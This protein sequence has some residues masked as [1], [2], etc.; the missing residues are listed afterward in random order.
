MARRQ[1]E[2]KLKNL[3]PGSKKILA[4][5]LPQ[6][7]KH[8]L[9]IA[10]SLLAILAEVGL[11]LLEPWPLKFIFDKLLVPELE[12]DSVHLVLSQEIGPLLLLSGL[13]L[14]IVSI[15]VL[16]ALATYASKLSM[17]MVAAK[18]LSDIRSQLYS[19]LQRLSLSFHYQYK[20]GDLISRVTGDIENIRNGMIDA[21]VPFA[22]NTVTLIGMIVVM[23]FINWELAAIALTMLLVFLLVANYLIGYIR[24]SVRKHRKSEAII[25][26]TTSETIGA[27]KIVQALSLHDALERI[28]LVQNRDNLDR[29]TEALKISALLLRTVQIL[30]AITIAIVLWRGAILV[31]NKSLTPGDLLVFISYLKNSFEPPL[32]KFANQ[33]GAIVK[34]IASGERIVDILE[35]EPNVRNLT[36]AKKAHPFFGAIKFENVKFGYNPNQK[37]LQGLNLAVEAGQKI[38]VVGPSGSGK[39]TLISLLLRLYDPN[40][41]RILI[42]GQDLREYTLESL[43]SQISVVLQ[44]SY[45]FATTVRENIAYGNLQ[46]TQKEI[47]KAAK[48]ANAHEFII[49]LPEGYDTLLGES[50]G[51]LSG[52]QK[53]RIAIARAAIRKAPIAILDEPTTRLDNASKLAVMT[54]LNRLTKGKTTFLITHDLDTIENNDLIVYLEQGRILEY[55]THKE[56]MRQ[57]QRYATLY[58]LKSSFANKELYTGQT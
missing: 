15:A 29:G 9:L 17:A 3:I 7:A 40:Q 11:Q 34:T 35:Y 8:K 18:V 46:V 42:D 6:I 23:F 33:T 49:N 57:N 28:F 21:I 43:R 38:T 48:L 20:R 24:H 19:H 27:I 54:G 36:S 16:R 37:I 39:S 55:G 32:R 5:F 26:S 2:K 58:Q 47:E 14:T 41:G 56:L 22:I 50:G 31:M 51:N 12:G 44:D 53:Q 13:T 45:L 52:G 25:A 4:K 1:K 30:V 10:I